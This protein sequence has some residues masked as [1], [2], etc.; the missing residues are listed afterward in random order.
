MVTNEQRR[1]ER[2]KYELVYNNPTLN[3]RMG[4]ARMLDAE[5]D[6]LWAQGEGCQTYLDIGCGRGEMLQYAKHIGYI[7]AFGTEIVQELQT[8]YVFPLFAHELADHFG[9]GSIDL[10]SCFDV[11]EHLLPGDDIAL[12][13]NMQHVARRCMVVTANNKPSV[14][15]ATGNDLHINKRPYDEWD[16]IIREAWKGWN[17]ERVTGKTYVSETWRATK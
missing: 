15:P 4:G 10:V 9:P 8:D 3:Y 1:A 14:D 17:V 6:V 2:E 11:I 13:D 16:D 7:D 5:Q 12:L